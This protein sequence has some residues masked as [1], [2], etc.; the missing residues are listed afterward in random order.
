VHVEIDVG[1]LAANAPPVKESI[2][3]PLFQFTVPPLHCDTTNVVA[4]MPA[5]KVSMNPKWLSATSPVFSI[6]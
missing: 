2:F 4:V 5:G 1:V 6:V 3:V